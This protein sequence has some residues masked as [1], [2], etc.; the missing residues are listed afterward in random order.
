PGGRRARPPGD[1]LAAGPGGGGRAVNPAA[2]DRLRDVRPG[3]RW[4]VAVAHPDDE[5]FGCGRPSPGPPGT[6]PR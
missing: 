3:D 2:R 6:A 1:A 4:L 5:T